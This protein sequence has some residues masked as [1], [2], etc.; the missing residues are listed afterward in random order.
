MRHRAELVLAAILAASAC[1]AAA[2]GAQGSQF[3]PYGT[4][5]LGT[6][7]ASSFRDRAAELRGL[8]GDF[9][10]GRREL[11]D[12]FIVEIEAK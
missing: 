3:C 6:K 12:G 2:R 4:Y 5:S 10:V 7:Y 1:A 11:P 8:G 9:I